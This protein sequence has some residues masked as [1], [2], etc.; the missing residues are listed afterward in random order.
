MRPQDQ[1][2]HHGVMH[3]LQMWSTHRTC[4][5]YTSNYIHRLASHDNGRVDAPYRSKTTAKL[6]N[7]HIKW[8]NRMSYYQLRHHEMDFADA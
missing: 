3:M 6:H 4:D 5:K 2:S 8:I 7:I 1:T